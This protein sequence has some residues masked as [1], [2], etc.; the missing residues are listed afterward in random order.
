MAQRMVPLMRSGARWSCGRTAR[1]NQRRGFLAKV[2]QWFI[3]THETSPLP[4][5][6]CHVRFRQGTPRY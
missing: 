2:L 1:L 5:V 6:L 3:G 4:V